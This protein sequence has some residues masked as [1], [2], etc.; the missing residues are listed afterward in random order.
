MID[1]I[2]TDHNY[3]PYGAYVI[4]PSGERV[5]I[6]YSSID[7]VAIY[8][9]AANKTVSLIPDTPYLRGSP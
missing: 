3:E 4:G 8:I 7:R 2:W 6:Y 5:G 1:W 9:D